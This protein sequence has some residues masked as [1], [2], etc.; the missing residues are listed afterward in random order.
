MLAHQIDVSCAPTLDKGYIRPSSPPWGC[1]TLFVSMTDKE[2]RLCVDYQ[3][4]NAITIKNKYPLPRTDILFDQ[5]VGAQV[6][7]KIDL[8]SVY[9]Q[10]KICAEDIP[11]TAFSMRYGMYEYLVMCLD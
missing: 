3:P 1:P 2:L 5:L 10:I 9:H 6:L 7:T 8:R 11:R 4:L